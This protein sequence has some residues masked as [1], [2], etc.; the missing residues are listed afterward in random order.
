M[1]DV[2]VVRN[3][4]DNLDVSPR[5]DSY[6]KVI[7]HVSDETTYEYPIGTTSGR[8]LEIDNPFG[9][10]QMAVDLYNRLQGYQYQ[11]FDANGTQLDPSA[12]IGDALS[13]TRLYGGIYARNRKF[14]RLMKADVSAPQDEEINHEYEYVSATE[15]MFA[16]QFDDVKATF[17]IQNDKIEAR[18]EADTSGNKSTFG[19]RL[20]SDSWEV[21]AANKTVLKA[22]EDGL[23]VNGKVTA[24]SGTIGG[25]EIGSRAIYNNMPSM[26]STATSGVYL[27]TDGIKLGQNFKVTTSGVVTAS[28]M[29]LKGT[30]TF[31]NEDGSSAGTL[32]A[33][34]LRLFAKD[35]YDSAC[36]SDGYCY[37][38][39]GGGYTALDAFNNGATVNYMRANK[40]YAASE[41]YASSINFLGT[42]LGRS[43]VTIDGTT[44]AYVSW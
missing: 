12:E 38:G 41:L 42:N 39:A 7:I 15:R 44:I 14:G 21:F 35:A 33:A 37:K 16:R 29:R 26:D 36:K 11:P 32:S 13:A 18:V 34:N 17:A 25:F 43:T 40:M 31:L 9:T 1:S 3:R 27:G 28:S 23:E 19:W 8:T 30:I 22:T 24:T 4:I 10:Q 6:G 20:K 2:T 5:F